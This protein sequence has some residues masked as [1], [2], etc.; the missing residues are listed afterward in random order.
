MDNNFEKSEIK[1]A[2]DVI[3]L[4]AGLA[5]MDVEGVEGMSSGIIAGLAKLLGKEDFTKGVKV[6]TKDGRVTVDVYVILRYGYRMPDV[7]INIQEKVKEQIE[8]TTGLE[9]LEVNVNIQGVK[10]NEE[11][12][13]FFE[14]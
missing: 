6:I 12:S 10:M 5:T 14:G 2:D 1:I 3:R 8:A 9:V 4:T 11:K 13:D 7:A